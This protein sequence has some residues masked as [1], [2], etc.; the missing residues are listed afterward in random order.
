MSHNNSYQF[1]DTVTVVDTVGEAAE[2]SSELQLKDSQCSPGMSVHDVTGAAAQYLRSWNQGLDGQEGIAADSSSMRVS[3]DV[4]SSVLG[5]GLLSSLTQPDSGILNLHG[6][7]NMSSSTQKLYQCSPAPRAHNK[8]PHNG[9]LLYQSRL[10]R[11]RVVI[12]VSSQHMSIAVLVGVYED[13]M[14]LAA[15]LHLVLSGLPSTVG[16][17][18]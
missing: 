6:S 15:W 8:K 4:A 5:S 13:C 10:E 1:M 7:S 17:S 12:K 3:S 18:P 16:H 11:M 14:T 9:T 2:V